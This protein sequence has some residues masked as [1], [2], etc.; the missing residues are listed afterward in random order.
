MAKYGYARCSTTEDRQD[1]ERQIRELTARG[2]AE[3]YPEY[4]SGT[5]SVRH[6]LDKLYAKLVEGDTI[7]V[8]EVSRLSRS[9]H[10]LLHIEEDAK[11]RKIRLECGSL[12]LDFAAEKV[13]PMAVAMYHMMGVFAELERGVTVERI[14]SGLANARAKGA[15]MGRPRK[16]AE[17][18]PEGVKNLLPRYEKGEFSKAEYARMAGISRFTLYKYL[19]LLG[20]EITPD[21]RLTVDDIPDLVKVHLADYQKGSIT[22]IE[23]ARMCGITRPTLDKYL[24]L[25]SQG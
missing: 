12:V 3:V 21:K 5:K 8:T 1:I 2:A 18:V 13:D 14:K 19:R 17:H 6:E 7:A 23:Y 20:V 16:T 24:K 25:L 9:L 11:A 10:H 4:V 22:K 15:S